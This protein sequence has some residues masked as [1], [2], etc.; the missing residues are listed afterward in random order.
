[1]SLILMA[2]EKKIHKSLQLISLD[3]KGR[4]R[5]FKNRS[6]KFSSKTG[7]RMDWGP[8]GFTFSTFYCFANL[9]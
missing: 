1:M 9:T 4:G 8:R 3:F 7:Q 5:S 6:F 2:Q